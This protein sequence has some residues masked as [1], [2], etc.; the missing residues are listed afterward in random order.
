[1]A[2]VKCL[3]YSKRSQCD[4]LCQV[5]VLATGIGKSCNFILS[6][7]VFFHVKKKRSRV[8][9][10]NSEVSL[11][12]CKIA[13]QWFPQVTLDLLIRAYLDKGEKK[14]PPSHVYE[15]S[16]NGPSHAG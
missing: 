13:L 6:K 11:L 16:A 1:M 5:E 2:L 14:G 4:L 15:W 8:F 3:M 10:V 9:F 12:N 7:F